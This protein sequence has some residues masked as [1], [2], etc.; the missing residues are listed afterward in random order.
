MEGQI[1]ERGT[2]STPNSIP[3]K[4]I[5]PNRHHHREHP[6]PLPPLPLGHH[7]RSVRIGARIPRR[8]RRVRGGELQRGPPEV[9]A[10][11]GGGD[12][13]RRGDGEVGGGDAELLCGLLARGGREESGG[14]N[15]FRAPSEAF[16]DCA[17]HA[18]GEG[19]FGA[20]GG[21]DDGGAGGVGWHFRGCLG[22]GLGRGGYGR[23]GIGAGELELE[24][25]VDC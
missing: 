3:I 4:R 20:G 14:T 7:S 18:E 21:P 5:I 13:G 22:F 9:D 16:F 24:G 10:R 25:K 23:G 1:D 6:P 2:N 11:V 12:P 15:F 8:V 19:G 17:A